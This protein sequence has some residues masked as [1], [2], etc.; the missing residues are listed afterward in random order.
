MAK[1]INRKRNRKPIF[2]KKNKKYFLRRNIK[3]PRLSNKLNYI[4]IKLF[5]IIKVKKLVNYKLKLLLRIKIHLPFYILLLE[6]G[7]MKRLI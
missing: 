2:K 7:Y 5:R 4:I 1:Y 3:I 6:P